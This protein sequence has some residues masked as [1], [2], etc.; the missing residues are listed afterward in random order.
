MVFGNQPRRTQ[1]DFGLSGPIPPD[2]LLLMGLTFLSYTLG[3][4]QSTAQFIAA[5]QLTPRLWTDGFLW[6]LVTY[7][8]GTGYGGPLSLIL[9]LWMILMFG[10]PVF[11]FV[12]RKAFW[13]YFFITALVGAMAAVLTQVLL[14]AVGL[15]NIVP[16]PFVLING[17]FLIWTFLISAFAALYGHA[18]VL[19]MFILPVRA[20]WFV[21]IELAFAFLAFLSYHDFAGFIGCCAAIGASYLQFAGIS[22]GRFLHEIRLRIQRK[23]FEH[24]LRQLKKKGD[25][26]GDVVQGPWV[27]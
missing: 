5:I 17:Q 24:R 2:I 13:R 8:F 22:P 10:K 18:T 27:H 21:A 6:Q 3:A 25:G 23:W 14:A 11:F 4:F 19:L 15:G 26:D 7:P 20:S 9:G 12:G 1:F 16:Q